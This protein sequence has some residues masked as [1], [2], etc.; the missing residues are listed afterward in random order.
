MYE[1]FTA[2]LLIRCEMGFTAKV[3]R[4]ALFSTISGQITNSN[5]STLEFG[6]CTLATTE[7]RTTKPRRGS[8]RQKTSGTADFPTMGL[9]VGQRGSMDYLLSNPNYGVLKNALRASHNDALVAASP[10]TAQKS[11]GANQRGY[12]STADV[13]SKTLII[14]IN[15]VRCPLRQQT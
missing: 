8:S 5:I 7:R 4:V 3:I 1:G 10:M 12:T 14:S 15:F 11:V 2:Q 6:T 9:S 13:Q